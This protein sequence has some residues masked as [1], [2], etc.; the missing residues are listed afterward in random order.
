MC[1]CVCVCGEIEREGGRG[2]KGKKETEVIRI[3]MNA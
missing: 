3:C 2:E 1:V